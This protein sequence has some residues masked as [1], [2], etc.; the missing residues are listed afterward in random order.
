MQTKSIQRY[1]K[2]IVGFATPL[3]VALILTV[4]ENNGYQVSDTAQG[5][6]TMGVTGFLVWLIPNKGNV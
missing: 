1:N 4:A 6:L 3:A 5:L 2:A